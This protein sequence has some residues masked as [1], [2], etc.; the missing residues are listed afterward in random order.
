MYVQASKCSLTGGCLVILQVTALSHA[1]PRRLGA[2][3]STPPQS[4][5]RRHV[6]LIGTSLDEVHS[7]PTEDKLTNPKLARG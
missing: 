3:I 2:D 1:G 7:P 5:R 4:A 6:F